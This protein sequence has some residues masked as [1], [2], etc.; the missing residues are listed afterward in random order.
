MFLFLAGSPLPFFSIAPL[1]LLGRQHNTCSLFFQ[2]A[3][4]RIERHT[5]HHITFSHVRASVSSSGQPVMPP[6]LLPPPTAPNFLVYPNPAPAPPPMVRPT[7]ADTIIRGS[8]TPLTVVVAH[9][10]RCGN[11]SANN[12]KIQHKPCQSCGL[13][14]TTPPPPKQNA[15]CCPPPP[16][17]FK[18]KDSRVS[19]VVVA[20]TVRVQTQSFSPLLRP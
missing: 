9:Q 2:A 3:F 7:A 12:K 14:H 4:P 16:P 19:A 18:E 11:L 1:A 5:P 13:T 20:K 8:E 17:P 6:L 15:F 10:P